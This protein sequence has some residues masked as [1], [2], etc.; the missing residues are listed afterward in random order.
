LIILPFSGNGSGLA[1]WAIL[2]I[3]VGSIAVLSALIY[4]IK[5]KKKVEI[6]VEDTP[7]NSNYLTVD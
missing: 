4:F 2:L 6:L 7:I 5:K 1:W 3:C